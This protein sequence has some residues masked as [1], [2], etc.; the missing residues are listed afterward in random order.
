MCRV[1]LYYEMTKLDALEE[2][3]SQRLNEQ[4]QAVHKTGHTMTT[5]VDE[6]RKTA[7]PR[8]GSILLLNLTQS[9]NISR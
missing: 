1:R 4:G 6:L 9:L 8:L 3:T 2:E 7:R 5:V